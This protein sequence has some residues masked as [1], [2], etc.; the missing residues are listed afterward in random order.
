MN[1]KH[2][3]FLLLFLFSFS[4]FLSLQP[5]GVVLA[6]EEEEEDNFETLPTYRWFEEDINDSVIEE[7]DNGYVINNTN[8]NTTHNQPFVRSRALNGRDFYFETRLAFETPNYTF[9]Q[10]KSIYPD[11]TSPNTIYHFN[12]DEQASGT[13]NIYDQSSYEHKIYDYN[14]NTGNFDSFSYKDEAN[15]SMYSEETY[16]YVNT[17][18]YD[19]D[20]CPDF[21]LGFWIYVDTLPETQTTALI[22]SKNGAYECFMRNYSLTY[23]KWKFIFRTAL[24]GETS[25]NY[26]SNE[27]ITEDTWYFLTFTYDN[28]T[29]YGKIYINGSLDFQEE[30]GYW[31]DYPPLNQNTTFGDYYGDVYY[32]LDDLFFLNDTLDSTEIQEYYEN[33]PVYQLSG[34]LPS[35]YY[36]GGFKYSL[37]NQNHEETGY[38]GMS[39]YNNSFYNFTVEFYDN[40]FNSFLVYSQL[41]EYEYQD[42]LRLKVQFHLDKKK[43]KLQFTYDNFEEIFNGDLYDLYGDLPREQPIAFNDKSLPRLAINATQKPEYR[44]IVAIDYIDSNW[45]LLDWQDPDRRFPYGGAIDFIAMDQDYDAFQS[46]SPYGAYFEGTWSGSGLS[47]PD[48]WA[49]RWFGLDITRFDGISWKLDASHSDMDVSG[50]TTRFWFSIYNVMPNGS[51]KIACWVAYTLSYTTGSESHY[52]GVI[53]YNENSTDWDNNYLSSLKTKSHTGEFDISFNF[54]VDYE[55][56]QPVCQFES[57]SH[58]DLNEGTLA[59]VWNES[60]YQ[61]TREW[62]VVMQFGLTDFDQSDDDLHIWKVSQFDITRKDILGDIVGAILS[63]ILEGFLLLLTPIILIFQI[64]IG[65]LKTLFDSLLAGFVSAIGGIAQ[66]IWNVFGATIESIVL[67]LQGLAQDIIDGLIGV[68]NNILTALGTIASDIIDGLDDLLSAITT[69]VQALVGDMMDALEVA[70]GDLFQALMD[71]METY[72]TLLSDFWSLVID[73]IIEE[74]IFGVIQDLFIT[75]GMEDVFDFLIALLEFGGVLITSGVELI[76]FVIQVLVFWLMVAIINYQFL[77]SI[78]VIG[79]V[80]YVVMPIASTIFNEGLEEMSFEDWINGLEEAVMRIARVA[81]Y[82]FELMKFILELMLR[83]AIAIG[84]YIPLT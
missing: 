46:A 28:T 65:I 13:G 63:P 11:N 70:I 27:N 41:F 24:G 8:Q 77:F 33:M 25:W 61:F 18:A 54:Y 36:N 83:I 81:D 22:V 69:A 7:I 78:I 2:S 17:S 40:D 30:G 75:L 62:Y 58:P 6:S 48:L 42:W 34:Y 50:D 35:D 43:L 1:S 10:F 76:A 57:G 5:T 31:N 26:M 80:A 84:N 79:V 64:L 29:E 60:V 49:T 71:A 12:F 51:L 72:F 82:L 47:K 19:L 39:F 15:S 23:Y 32:Y 68:L 67:T 20:W 37:L 44:C 56:N 9:Q 74:V 14:W 53:M 55:R 16:H 21:T 59:Q 45:R 66:S 52:L 73:W 38:F 4:I 3:K